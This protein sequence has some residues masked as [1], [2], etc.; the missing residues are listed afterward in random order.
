MN[1][2]LFLRVQ[3]IILMSSSVIFPFYLLLIRELGDSYA[4]FGLAYGLFT[5]TSAFAYLAIGRFSDRFGDRVLLVVHTLGMAL[6]LLYIPVVTAIS[7]VYFIQIAMGL[8][9][10]IQKNTE[11]TVLARQEIATTVVGRHIGGYH[12]KTSLWSA[13][14]IIV[15]GYLIDFLTI[16][17]LFYIISVCYFYATLRLLLTSPHTQKK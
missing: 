11:K 14:G 9:G 10:A 4:Q 6:L 7:H 3:S 16:G 2:P 12:F 17:S 5:V 13:G 8:L 1:Y 15:A